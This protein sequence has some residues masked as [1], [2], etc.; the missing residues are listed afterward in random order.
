[1]NRLF[2]LGNYRNRYFVMRHG[3]SEANRRGIIVSDPQNGIETFGLS[4]QGRAEVED[5]LLRY[6]RLDAACRIVSSDFLRALE[7]AETARRVIGCAQPVVTDPRLRERYFGD[8]EMQPNGA[9]ARIW[10]EDRLNPD[11]ERDR[12]ESANRVMQ[13]VTSLVVDLERDFDGE[14][15]LLVS[16][17]DAIQILQTAFAGRDAALHRDLEHLETAEIRELTAPL[18]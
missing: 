16:H 1:M 3:H 18:S 4:E 9:Y 10:E 6:E 5:S 11:S 2:E 15:F 14:T 12:V 17:G 13:R 7:T 8:F